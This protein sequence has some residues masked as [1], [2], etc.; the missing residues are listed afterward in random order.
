M[1]NFMNQL[2]WLMVPYSCVKHQSIC[3]CEGTFLDVIN[4]ETSRH[5]LHDVGGLIQSV[6]D[7]KSKDRFLLKTVMQKPRLPCQPALRTLDPRVRRHLT[8]EFPACRPA[9]QI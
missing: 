9:V 6:E 2:G 1:I 3:C 7:L 8:L 5:T 4:T